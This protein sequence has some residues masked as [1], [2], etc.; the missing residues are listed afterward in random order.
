MSL[1]SRP[2]LN[3][4]LH[5]SLYSSLR[6]YFRTSFYFSLSSQ[7]PSL[8]SS[9]RKNLTLLILSMA[10]L[11]LSISSS[12]VF[13]APKS[14]GEPGSI[15]GTETDMVYYALEG[16]TLS[17]I[18][19]RFTEKTPNWVIIGKVNNITNDRTIPIGSLILIPLDLLP[20][21][22]V[23][24]KVLAMAGTSTAKLPTGAEENIALGNAYKEGTMITTGKNGF[25]TLVLPDDSRISIPS[26]SQ[27][28]LSKLRITKHSKSPRTEITLL[29]GRVESK[30]TPLESNKGRF[31][32]RSPLAVA[33]VR[34]THFRVSVNDNGIANEVLSGGVA[35]GSVKKPNTLVIPAGKGNVVTQQGVGD[36]VDLLPP[37]TLVGSYQLQEKPTLVFNLEKSS[38]A[39]SYHVQIA[40]DAAIQNVLTE[41]R[42][43]EERI[44]IDGLEDGN[45][46]IRASTI[47]SV[48]LEGLPLIQAFTLKARPEPPFNVLPKAKIRAEKV[49]FV[50]TEAANTQAYH[51]QVASDNAFEKIVLDQSDIKAV[52]YSAD[53]LT[54]G[55]YYWRIASITQKNGMANQ[56]PYSDTKVVNFLPVQKVNQPSDRDANFLTFNWPSEPGQVFLIQ[57]GRDPSFADI[58]FF[59]KIDKPEL[60]IPRVAPGDYFIRVRATDADGYVGE[61]S[62]PQKF[63]VE[64]R[65]VSRSGDPIKSGDA[66]VKP[67]F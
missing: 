32:V 55:K 4:L 28:K 50:W 54:N 44:K 43:A 66:V 65:W 38:E 36:A 14:T 37:P 19:Q 62:A 49:D 45:Y 39:K 1:A 34:G 29:Q 31:E 48:G 12:A 47:D 56:G 8:R 9:L 23:E 2:A 58:Y 21:D 60:Q 15:S 10:S 3:P 63:T 6:S 24:A 27:V 53:K 26:N 41:V 42:S 7:L 11:V 30:V 17:S 52:Q 22:P 5:S 51:L 57:I 18:A 25:L 59:R 40:S 67:S 33:G 35:V 20:A 13:A 61:F 16:D 64:S 46:F